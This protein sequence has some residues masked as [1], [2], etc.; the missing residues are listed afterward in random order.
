MRDL[1]NSV[2]SANKTLSKRPTENNFCRSFCNI[3]GSL[4]RVGIK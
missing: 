2:N 4:S 3:Y 1:E